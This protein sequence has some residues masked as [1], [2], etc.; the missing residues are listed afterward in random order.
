MFRT[1]FLW[2]FL[3][4]LLLFGL[5]AAGGAAL[6]RAGFAQGYQAAALAANST[7][8][9]AAPNL[10]APGFYPSPYFWPAYSYPGFFPFGPLLGIGFFLLVFFLIGGLFRSFAW[11]HYAGQPGHGDWGHGPEG[12]WAKEW[13]ERHGA[14]D[15][16]EEGAS[17]TPV[18]K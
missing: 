16:P 2:R 11:R 5:L 17:E 7:G 15:K 8:N 13:K 3:L 1:G 18:E 4:A 6:Y 9:A 12:R 10:P 14:P